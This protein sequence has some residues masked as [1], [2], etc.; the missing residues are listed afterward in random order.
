VDRLL[1]FEAPTSSRKPTSS[2]GRCVRP[3]PMILPRLSRCCTAPTPSHAARGRVDARRGPYRIVGGVRFYE[4][5]EI[6][7]T[8]AI[9]FKAPAQRGRHV[10]FRRVV[11]TPPRGIGKVV[12]DPSRRPIPPPCRRSAPARRRRLHHGAGKRSLWARAQRVARRAP[13]CPRRSARFEGF[14][15]LVVELRRWPSPNLRRQ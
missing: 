14:P 11:N 5:K 2:A 4:R 3:T 13:A 9:I 15:T 1:Y 12:L 7:D 6:K 10:S 8:L